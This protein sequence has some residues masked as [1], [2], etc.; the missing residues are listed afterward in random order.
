MPTLFATG[1]APIGGLVGEFAKVVRWSAPGAVLI[2]STLLVV[3]VGRLLLWQSLWPVANA[4]PPRFVAIDPVGVALLVTATVPIGFLLYQVYFYLHSRGSGL[5]FQ[6]VHQDI[7]AKV[8]LDDNAG[9]KTEKSEWIA[10]VRQGIY[11][12]SPRG[13]ACLPLTSGIKT[14]WL[15]NRTSGQ[16][17]S[18]TRKDRRLAVAQYQRCLEANWQVLETRIYTQAV[19]DDTARER[20]FANVDRLADIYHT[21]GASKL[22]LGAGWLGGVAWL[23]GSAALDSTDYDGARAVLITAVG[24]ALAL[25]VVL[26][27]ALV[28]LHNNRLH[29]QRRRIAALKDACRLRTS[30]P[31][32]EGCA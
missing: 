31:Q 23:A 17:L 21:L 28:V 10:A 6:F 18:G 24:T 29:C 14:L 4:H 2:L 25:L 3:A 26:V 19:V 12:R 27:L 1:L 30:D 5:I 22:A 8:L 20:I 9:A 13:G 16:P 15:E 32:Q 11:I 7:G